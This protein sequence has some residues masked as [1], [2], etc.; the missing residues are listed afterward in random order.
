MVKVDMLYQLDLR[1][2]EI[3]EKV[4]VPFGGVA[5][6]TFGDM[7]QLKPCMGRYI[8]DDPIGKDF[9]ITHA[10]EP[11]WKMFKSLIL[12]TNHRQGNDKAYADLLN[13]VRVE[14]QRNDDIELLRTRVRPSNHKDLKAASLYIV[15]K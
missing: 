9:Q 3:M 6:F 10:I 13:R 4:G 7:M 15:C 2:Q 14:N 1:L 8:C 11:R 5:I 12:E